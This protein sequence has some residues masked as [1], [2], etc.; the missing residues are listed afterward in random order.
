MNNR[1]G[2]IV[3]HVYLP[4]FRYTLATGLIPCLSKQSTTIIG[5]KCRYWQESNRKVWLADSALPSCPIDVKGKLKEWSSVWPD[6]Q[7]VFSIFGHLQQW[8][9]AQKHTNC[10]KVNWK[11]CP[12]PNKPEIIC[13]R[14]L[15]FAKVVEF[16]QIWTHCRKL[17][18]SFDLFRRRYSVPPLRLAFDR[19]RNTQKSNWRK[20][21]RGQMGGE[22]HKK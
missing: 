20:T 3:K 12:K 11:L 19:N 14:F 2:T 7:I 10:V 9:I 5:L 16:R 1:I 4:N 13:H 21:H 8:T 18:C 22:R 15:I 17:K 6:D